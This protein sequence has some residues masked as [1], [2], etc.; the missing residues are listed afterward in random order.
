MNKPQNTGSA[1]DSGLPRSRPSASRAPDS[2]NRTAQRRLIQVMPFID[3]R[4]L[5]ARRQ[6]HAWPFD[7]AIRWSHAGRQVATDSV[8]ITR[9]FASALRRAGYGVALDVPSRH[10]A[11]GRTVP[12][13]VLMGRI[14]CFNFH[15]H[16]STLLEV[17]ISISLLDGPTL[18]TLWQ[19]DFPV[20]DDLP[21]WIGL[22]CRPEE[23]TRTAL[24]EVEEA[25]LLQFQSDPF[26]RAAGWPEADRGPAPA[27]AE[28]VHQVVIASSWTSTD[29]GH[30]TAAAH[31]SDPASSSNVGMAADKGEPM[32]RNSRQTSANRVDRLQTACLEGEP[33]EQA[34]LGRSGP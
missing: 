14:W 23:M 13:T 10:A 4:S 12:P 15:T 33:C 31:E 26:R 20:E 22:G 32:S 24:R 2:S 34:R 29:Q 19:V 5:G 1:C 25:A 21:F 30:I 7:V 11:G 17:D 16:A 6:G 28:P 18:E 8:L 27:E 9:V 3:A